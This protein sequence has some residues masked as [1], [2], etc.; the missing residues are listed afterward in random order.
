MFNEG[1]CECDE[2][3]MRSLCFLAQ[4]SLDLPKLETC[5]VNNWMSSTFVY[6]CNVVMESAFLFT[7]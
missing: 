6:L 3:I 1:S 7:I 4:L 2:L 5:K